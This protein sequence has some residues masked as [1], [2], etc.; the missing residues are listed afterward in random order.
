MLGDSNAGLLGGAVFAL[1]VACVCVSDVR[2]R[3]I[4]NFLVV[5]VGV[6]GICWSIAIAPWLT[7]GLRA[8]GGLGVGLAIWLP[9][10]A[11]RLL[12]AGDVKFFAAAS[13]WLGPGGAFDA[14]LLSALVGGA[15][16]LMYVFRDNHWMLVLAR[17]SS[18]RGQPQTRADTSPS[19]MPPRSR[20]PYGV[21][22]AVGLLVV[23]WF[24][25]LL[26]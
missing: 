2:A 19:D 6:T 16:A 5:L 12:G 4:P 14:A 21:A 24:P 20:L 17:L 22:M 11:V 1:L 26:G 13:A 3:R 15:I 8:L 9:F 10:Y 18:P 7:G 25:G 23:A